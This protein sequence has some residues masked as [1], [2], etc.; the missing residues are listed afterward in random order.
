ML[1]WRNEVG[2]IEALD[3]RRWRWA[4]VEDVGPTES[5]SSNSSREDDDDDDD[6]S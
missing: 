1:L 3:R 2:K 6:E 4:Q 5:E